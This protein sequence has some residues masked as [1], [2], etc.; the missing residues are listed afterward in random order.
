MADQDKKLAGAKTKKK[1]IY[2]WQAKGM[3]LGRTAYKSKMAGLENDTFD[4][5]AAS[6]PAKFSKLL[7]K[8]LH[9]EDLLNHWKNI[10]S[11]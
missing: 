8:E 10:D 9:P 5:G 2:G 7:K 11:R 6:N 1:K 3:L 4:V